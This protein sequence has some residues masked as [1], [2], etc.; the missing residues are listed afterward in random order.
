[1]PAYYNEH[2][3]FAAAWLR[4]LIA[5]GLIAAGEVDERDIQ[6]VRA[7]DLR[8]F[9][10]CHFFAGIGGWSYALRLAGWPDDRAVWTGSCPCQPWSSAGKQAGE[11]DERHL[12]PEWFRLLA[13]SRPPVVFGEQVA[14]PAGLRWLDLVCGDLEGADYTV[15]AADLC[16]AGAG[17]PDIRQRLWFVAD[18]D[19][20]TDDAQLRAEQRDSVAVGRSSKT[21][22][23][24]GYLAAGE[25]SE[26]ERVADADWSRHGRSR[27]SYGEGLRDAVER[28]SP[29]RELGNPDDARSQ[30]RVVGR[31]NPDQRLVGTPSLAGCVGNA[32]SNRQQGQSVRTNRDETHGTPQ[33]NL[34]G[35]WT[36][37]DW[38]P[39]RDGKWRPVEPGTFPLA[40]GLPA[41][42]G[43]LRG[44]GNAIK[45]QVAAIFIRAAEEAR[46]EI[47]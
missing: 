18:A 6:A 2:D 46:H 16:G 41:R 35:V 36:A 43:R 7:D 39:C 34:A 1:M 26:S 5:A 3:P 9:T 37:C 12:W 8:G 32:E 21:G 38:I 15:G 4:T 24:R 13:E 23:S 42:V 17:S 29:S 11:A 19:R 25:Q 40:H 27:R 30:G 20:G 33:A 28:H 44:Y 47:A 14:G 10:Q 22:G 45:P 31:L